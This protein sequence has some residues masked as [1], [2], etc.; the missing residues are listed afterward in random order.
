MRILFCPAT[1][2]GIELM[3]GE[4]S[5]RNNIMPFLKD[6]L[7]GGVLSLILIGWSS[8]AGNAANDTIHY[9]VEM[10]TTTIFLIVFLTSW[11]SFALS[12]NSYSL[13]V[14]CGSFWIAVI[15]LT[16]TISYGKEEEASRAL[17]HW[18][19][20]SILEALLLLAA[21]L[22]L[23]RAVAR[24]PVF[25][26]LGAIAAAVHATISLGPFPDMYVAGSGVTYFCFA[27][28]YGIIVVYTGAIASTIMHKKQH[29]FQLY[30][31]MILSIIM[32]IA[33]DLS[34][35]PYNAH[36]IAD[37][38]GHVFR[39]FSFWLIFTAIVHRAL[40]DP[41]KAMAL[42]A[43]SFDSHPDPTILVD[44]GG[45]IRQVNRA[46]CQSRNLSR[47][48]LLGRSCHDHF[49]PE[50]S[51]T[52]DC[53]I[54]RHIRSA[55]TM[56]PT[57][58]AY[59][60]K[61][62]QQVAVTPLSSF[63]ELAGM[64]H[65]SRDVTARKQTTHD[66]RRR[67]VEQTIIAS[68]LG[69]FHDSG[70][71]S[72]NEILQEALGLVVA[73]HGLG[74]QPVGCIFLR[75]DDTLEM[76][77]QLNLT[78]C[79]LTTC[80][81]IP[82][83][84]C[85]CGRAA[86]DNAIVF[87]HEVDHRHDVTFPGMSPHGHY[88][89]PIQ[90]NGE[91]IGVLN[92]YVPAHHTSSIDEVRFLISV[93]NALAIIIQ[94]KRLEENETTIRLE[95]T[96]HVKDLELAN[97]A[98]ERQ[99][100]ALAK[101]AEEIDAERRRTEHARRDAER[102]TKA[103]S[104]F[105]ANMS[106]E[107]RTPM[108]GVVTMADLLN[109]TE[110]TREQ[111]S[112]LTVIRES[113]TALLGIINDILDFSKI[114]A[115]RLTLETTDV[116]LSDLVEGVANVLEPKAFEKGIGL[117]GCIDPHVPNHLMGD[118]VRLRQILLNLVGNAVKFTEHGEVTIDVTSKAVTDK[119]ATVTFV[120]RDTGIGISDENQKKL[121][122]PFSQAD[123]SIARRFGGTGL[124]LSISIALVEMMGGR[125]GVKSTL[126]EGSTFWFSVDLTVVVD[127]RRSFEN[128][129]AGKRILLVSNTPTLTRTLER[130][131]LFTGAQL[132][133]SDNA[134]AA[135]EKLDPA[136]DLPDVVLLDAECS[137]DMESRA[138]MEIIQAAPGPS[139]PK[140]IVLMRRARIMSATVDRFAGAEAI[141]PVPV[142][143]GE[144]W[145]TM[146]TVLGLGSPNS[147]L[148]M[149]GK[150]G[151]SNINYQAPSVDEARARGALILV[152]EDNTINQ[153]VIGTL[154]GKLGYAI[155]I[156]SNGREAW[157]AIKTG[158][159]GLLLTDCHMP[160]MDGYSLTSI[161]RASERTRGGKRL[162]VIALTADAF[163]GAGQRCQSSGMDACLTKPIERE[164]LDRA[165]RQ[166]LPVAIELRKPV[167][168]GG[169]KPTAVISNP[170]PHNDADDKPAIPIL[171]LTYLANVVDNDEDM[172]GALLS[173]LL[174]MM[175]SLLDEMLAALDAG[176]FDRARK[177][178]HNAKGA[179]KST[180]A[181]ELA[182]VC[183]KIQF[184]LDR[185]DS[186]T[187]LSYRNGVRPVF[188]ALKREIEA[189][190]QMA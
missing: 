7:L 151:P 76:V 115:G 106:H 107:I 10:L 152:A 98:L 75:Q 140:C 141:L 83:G 111:G 74:L 127:K 67:T 87:A 53:P 147:D 4:S 167:D 119:I 171:D 179:L 48:D 144:I 46:A 178:A 186:E 99:T 122:T 155:Q 49:H 133:F 47:D 69:L 148:S 32:A 13:F 138:L 102:A 126:G 124:G 125:I 86:A 168:R 71:R 157:D 60:D 114:E 149:R 145:E 95:L 91:A 6:I 101:L 29:T 121:F 78:T 131:V 139:R 136:G 128:E 89:V 177:V 3:N 129:L 97:Q 51:S 19:S 81:N 162:P 12:K 54:C 21:P 45:L 22:F 105:L 56:P 35:P 112:M 165:I 190:P 94:R 38:Q 20:I 110:L 143:R 158:T 42:G 117:W 93:A 100:T 5:I 135:L 103:K 90:S 82:L 187:A 25:I 52:E 174:A 68:I 169:D 166:H 63:D 96:H 66:L 84:Y 88:C 142:S 161:I 11:Y 57:D 180:G 55:E 77:A 43:D 33:G 108:N 27:S 41:F 183:E 36:G 132:V 173:D 50:T 181:F 17:Q 40:N 39:L 175:P 85:L 23:T 24:W 134:P 64:V 104:Q 156:V 58:F 160:E 92:F 172:L 72:L 137:G 130:Y 170:A 73:T 44:R 159:Y 37:I 116:S 16:H 26:I 185:K 184:A 65:V 163:A 8:A 182:D 30:Y 150:R 154:L 1:F 189:L 15:D 61:T 113:G 18:T 70:A 31:V 176:E 109:D 2:W 34:P 14:G 188:D 9:V 59:P 118:P 164:A 123:D 80:A 79:L 28:T 146:A 62:W 153:T 120:V